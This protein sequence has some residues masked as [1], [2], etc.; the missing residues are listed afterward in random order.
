MITFSHLNSSNFNDNF[1]DNF[2]QE[3]VKSILVVLILSFALFLFFGSLRKLVTPLVC[4]AVSKL[5]YWDSQK[6]Y[7]Y[8][9]TTKIVNCKIVN[10]TEW[11]QP[12]RSSWRRCSIKKALLKISQNLQENN[13][14][15]SLFFNKV[16]VLRPATL[17][18]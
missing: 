18:K 7:C 16:A 3:K 10:K 11:F 8:Q 13:R 2:M 6:W 4:N 14:V 15:Q 12:K 9:L 5:N 17:L 1:K